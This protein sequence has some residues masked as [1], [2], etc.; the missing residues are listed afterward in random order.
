MKGQR[1][2]ACQIPSWGKGSMFVQIAK[3]FTG[4]KPI[5]STSPPLLRHGNSFIKFSGDSPPMLKKWNKE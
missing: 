5:L 3:V 1:R 2:E 4:E